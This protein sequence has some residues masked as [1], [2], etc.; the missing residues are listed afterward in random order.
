MLKCATFQALK[1]LDSNWSRW[2]PR[3][4][5]DQWDVDAHQILP[6]RPTSFSD[7]RRLQRGLRLSANMAFGL[8]LNFCQ[9]VRRCAEYWMGLEL[10]NWPTAFSSWYPDGGN[11][12]FFIFTTICGVSW[13]NLMNAHIFK[14]AQPPT[15]YVFGGDSRRPTLDFPHK[16]FISH[17]QYNGITPLEGYSSKKKC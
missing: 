14:W 6:P 12:T 10:G 11:S 9:K 13:S 4:W 1:S 3:Y 5:K 17:S 8:L 16:S 15:R 2:W 7:H